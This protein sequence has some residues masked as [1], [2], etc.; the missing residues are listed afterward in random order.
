MTSGE[1][2]PTISRVVLELDRHSV[3]P[4]R[5]AV[6]PAEDQAMILVVDAEEFALF[7]LGGAVSGE[8]LLSWRGERHPPATLA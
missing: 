7:L 8:R 6:R 1:E 5:D 3:W 4:E 2:C